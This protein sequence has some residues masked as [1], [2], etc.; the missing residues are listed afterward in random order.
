ML[1]AG[2]Q[3]VR[4]GMLGSS[5]AYH[6]YDHKPAGHSWDADKKVTLKVISGDDS[7]SL[8][9][10]PLPVTIGRPTGSA[11][12]YA[13]ANNALFNNSMISR[14]HATIFME[15]KH[16]HATDLG[17]SNGTYLNGILMKAHTP[18]RLNDGDLLQF[19][20]DDEESLRRKEPAVVVQVKLQATPVENQYQASK[21]SMPSALSWTETGK[22]SF[23]PGRIL[24]EARSILSKSSKSFSTAEMNPLR[25]SATGQMSYGSN[26][27]MQP[28]M[29]IEETMR[30]NE[31]SSQLIGLAQ[32][33]VEAAEA[34]KR[35][36]LLRP[37][38]LGDLVQSI[39]TALQIY[40][41]K[42]INPTDATYHHR[43][44]LADGQRIIRT[45]EFILSF[46]AFIFVMWIFC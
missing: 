23:S 32:R 19:G 8:R 15:S 6:D 2:K 17:S 42:P 37:A 12:T 9:I 4:G 3:G 5:S 41:Q 35:S 18:Y 1:R 20:L 13:S 31:L 45:Y 30:V 38:E 33:V 25:R 27:A 44:N 36:D 21:P 10:V 34:S 39:E 14:K 43:P 7:N 29:R 40:H 24:Q 28:S 46:L 16:L 22:K 11:G 26:Y